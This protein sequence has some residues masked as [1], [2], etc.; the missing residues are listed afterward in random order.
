M[1]VLDAFKGLL[2]PERKA[3]IT[4]S[5]MNTDHVVIPRGMTSQLIGQG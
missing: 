4:D 1:L 5:S 3:T 2:T